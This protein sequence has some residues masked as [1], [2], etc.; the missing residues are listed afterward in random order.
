MWL[1]V[2]ASERGGDPEFREL[3]ERYNAF[4]P[5]DV[6]IICNSHHA[7]IHII[8]DRIIREHKHYTG[9]PLY[10]YSWTEANEL[11]DLLEGACDTW[12]GEETPGASSELL[13]QDRRKNRQA[14]KKTKRRRRK[15]RK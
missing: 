11:M 10:K 3:V 15:R 4:L 14:Q 1:G 7:E 5:E 8:Y 12:L 13:R 9:K 2:W 6:V